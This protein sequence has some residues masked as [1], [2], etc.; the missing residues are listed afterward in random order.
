M[1]A[2]T[3][4]YT[5][6]NSI[7]V[8][9]LKNTYQDANGNEQPLARFTN[10]NNPYWVAY[11][12]FEN[13]RRDRLFG[14]LSLRYQL[15]KWLY[16]Q[17]RFGQDYFTRPYNYDRPTGTRSIGAVSS[18]FN[19]YYYQDVSTF[20]ERNMDLLIGANKTFGKFGIDLTVGG[21]QM[22][23]VSD[24]IGTAV[25]NFYVRDLYTIGNG[26]TKNPF[27]NYGKKTNQFNLRRSRILL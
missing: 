17:G 25:T 18:G 5:L 4:I 3:T 21:N 9:W 2:N 22:Q 7:D 26:Q 12:R 15:A 11:K 1:N 19:G 10:R 20:R 24:N 16:V 27:Y 8:H 23:Q 14:N 6:A 13:V